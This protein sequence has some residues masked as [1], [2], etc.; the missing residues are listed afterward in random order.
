MGIDLTL[1]PVDEV[2]QDG[3][4]K[5]NIWFY[6]DLNSL[7]AL[8]N[9]MPRSAVCGNVFWPIER[10]PDS[11][12]AN[13][14]PD[15]PFMDFLGEPVMFANATVPDLKF[16]YAGDVRRALENAVLDLTDVNDFERAAIA[17]ILN[18]DDQK[19]IVL[20]WC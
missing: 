2:T 6:L 3:D 8:F 19:Q 12:R 9:S 16:V 13:L 5:C 7:V 20:F 14:P 17:Y 18:L 11:L 15:T 4:F 10:V 1:L